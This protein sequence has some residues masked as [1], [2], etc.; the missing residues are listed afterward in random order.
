MACNFTRML[1]TGKKSCRYCCHLW[2]RPRTFQ[3]THV[4]P[5]VICIA[6]PYFS[7][8]SH[9]GHNFRRGEGYWTQNMFWFPLQLLSETFLLIRKLLSEKFLI[10]RKTGR[11]IVNVHSAKYPLF[12][13]GFNATWIFW[14]IFEKILEYQNSWKS[15]QWKRHVPCGRSGQSNMTI[16][17]LAFRNFANA[18]EKTQISSRNL[19]R[20]AESQ[21]QRPI[22]QST[23]RLIK[24]VR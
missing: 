15:A 5:S 23:S 14:Q 8:L 11:D 18:P 21:R 2:S 6:L 12:L 3:T 24:T 9:K 16:L 13:P 17:I 7:T 20:P 4:L 19:W 1:M 10:I 22:L